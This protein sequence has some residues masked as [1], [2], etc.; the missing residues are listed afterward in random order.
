MSLG[1]LWCQKEKKHP[2]THGDMITGAPLRDRLPA[3]VRT[4]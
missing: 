4:V 3:S 2:E 1:S